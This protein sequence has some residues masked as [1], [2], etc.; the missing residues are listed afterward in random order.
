MHSLQ[1]E[2]IELLH[3]QSGVAS[4]VQLRDFGMPF[5][6]VQKLI[7]LRIWSEVTNLVISTSS[8]PPTFKQQCWAMSLHFPAAVLTGAASLAF[9]GVPLSDPP[10]I[11]VIGTRSGRRVPLPIARMHSSRRGFE[12]FESPRRTRPAYSLIYA[13]AL[14]TWKQAE[15]FAT[16]AIQR[17]ICTLDEIL[18]ELAANPKSNIHRRAARA[19]TLLEP[20]THSSN[21]AVFLRE[22]KLRNWPKPSM[23]VPHVDS[24]GR[25]RY[26]DF[27]FIG[28]RR[29]VIVEIDGY[30][31]LMSKVHLDD[32]FRANS[33]T[34]E[35]GV[36]FRIS[37]LALR[38]DC[39]RYMRQLQELLENEGVLARRSWRNSA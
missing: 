15:F 35:G 39:E 23:Q 5:A 22:C 13:S 33:L 7:E 9:D 10:F 37:S 28:S 21:E 3:L 18:E 27:E 26:T 4:R 38:T 17:E 16:S 11:D 12:I 36:V 19:L 29:N 20:G 25:S 1:Q 32:Q 2:L 6:D 30:G 24:E 31:H 8:S 14:T 34:M